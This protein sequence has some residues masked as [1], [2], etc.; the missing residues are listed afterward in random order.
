MD[1]ENLRPIVM[2]EEAADASW[3]KDSVIEIITNLTLG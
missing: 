1:V 3:D 2:W